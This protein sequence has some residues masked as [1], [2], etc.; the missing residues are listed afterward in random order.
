[1]G[2]NVV[3][4]EVGVLSGPCSRGKD[5]IDGAVYFKGQFAVQ[6]AVSLAISPVQKHWKRRA[7]VIIPEK[8]VHILDIL[9]LSYLLKM[10][11]VMRGRSMPISPGFVVPKI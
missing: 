10:W 4:L 9:T 3:C 5:E 11:Y 1:M 2:Y 7:L 8:G 6:Q